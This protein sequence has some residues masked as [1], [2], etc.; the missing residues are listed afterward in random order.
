MKKCFLSRVG[1][2]LCAFVLMQGLCGCKKEVTSV[3]ETVSKDKTEIVE[4]SLSG[5]EEIEFT[6]TEYSYL[7]S[8]KYFLLIDKDITLP[9]N[10][11]IVTD[12][13]IDEVEKETG[14]YYDTDRWTKCGSIVATTYVGFEP[15]EGLDFGK[16]I[17]IYIFNDREPAGYISWASNED[18]VFVIYELMSDELWN[19]IPEYRDNPWRK[20]DYMDY[21]TIAHELTHTIVGRN[22]SLSK[23]MTEGIA[24][25]MQRVVPENLSKR[26]DSVV[27]EEGGYDGIPDAITRDN[28]EA[29]FLSDYAEIDHAHRGAEYTLGMIICDYMYETFG[30]D[31]FK[32]YV[33]EINNRNISFLY[34]NQTEEDLVKLA[35]AMKAVFGEDFFVNFGDWYGKN[36]DRYPMFF[37]V[38][39]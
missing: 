1:F 26:F 17:P 27:Y 37:A 19:S 5:I 21:A 8:D 10:F 36:V 6:T 23:I 16:K 39:E 31:A 4:I 35:E 22:V 34:G 25:R 9:G 2:I 20:R 14:L 13:I 28:A 11:K 29:I 33:D 32:R 24:T 18:T 7:E 3:S 15:W 38:V 30:N 12:A